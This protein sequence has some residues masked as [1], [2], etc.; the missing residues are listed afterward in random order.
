MRASSKEVALVSD[1]TQGQGEDGLPWKALTRS[2]DLAH[3]SIGRPRRHREATRR[4]VR[5]NALTRR[6]EGATY[7]VVP[8]TRT[9]ALRI[10]RRVCVATFTARSGHERASPTPRGCQHLAH[11]TEV[12]HSLGASDGAGAAAHAIQM[13]AAEP[14]DEGGGRLAFRKQG[15]LPAGP[16]QARPQS[17]GIVVADP[18]SA[19][20]HGAAVRQHE[21]LKG[22]LAS[23]GDVADVA[24]LIQMPGVLKSLGDVGYVLDG[25]LPVGSRPAGSLVSQVEVTNRLAGRESLADQDCQIL[26]RGSGDC[27]MQSLGVIKLRASHAAERES[28]AGL[29]MG[30]GKPFGLVALRNA[31][32][33]VPPLIRCALSAVQ[34]GALGVRDVH[35]HRTQC[36]R[37]SCATVFAPGGPFM[38]TYRVTLTERYDSDIGSV[39]GSALDRLD[40]A[41]TFD[42]QALAVEY[43]KQNKAGW[44]GLPI[45]DRR[46]RIREFIESRRSR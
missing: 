24:A 42:E 31:E 36:Q 30:H 10:H 40:R 14:E 8:P 41:V 7:R 21:P 44:D 6:V 33:C 5:R 18:E 2:R 4:Q 13:R 17:H 11:T 9:A 16:H 12:R 35:R 15:S 39:V 20:Q 43:Y 26:G 32:R 28:L 37:D 19:L 38:T 45:G 25:A 1:E 3:A 27:A 34:A 29:G 22:L 23:F 46:D